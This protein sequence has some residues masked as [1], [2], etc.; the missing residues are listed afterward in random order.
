MSLMHHCDRC[1]LAKPP[2]GPRVADAHPHLPERWSTVVVRDRENTSDLAA[3]KQVTLCEACDRS[4]TA[5][6]HRE[7]TSESYPSDPVEVA[8]S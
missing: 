4:L 3:R 8:A 1:N 5:W 6:F 7:R 2:K